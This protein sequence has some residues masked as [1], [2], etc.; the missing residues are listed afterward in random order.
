MHSH[1]IPDGSPTSSTKIIWG[2]VT[3]CA[4]NARGILQTTIY[5]N[6]GVGLDKSIN[7]ITV[8]PHNIHQEKKAVIVSRESVVT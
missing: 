7:Y 3:G 1:V 5:C 6:M 4:P 2:M 8:Q